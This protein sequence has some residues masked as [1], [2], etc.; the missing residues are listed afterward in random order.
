MHNYSFDILNELRAQEHSVWAG[1][2]NL[3]VQE[4]LEVQDEGLEAGEFNLEA[5]DWDSEAENPNIPPTLVLN[6]KRDLPRLSLGARW[7]TSKYSITDMFLI[8]LLI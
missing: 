3:K 1:E 4:G 8:C 7:C 5:G 6:P 2:L